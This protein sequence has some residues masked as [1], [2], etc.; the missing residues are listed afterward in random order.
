MRR[1]PADP[2]LAPSSASGRINIPPS[3]LFIASSRDISRCK[4]DIPL[5]WDPR[6]H[7]RDARDRARPSAR[8]AVFR[9][10]PFVDVGVSF[11]R[12]L[13]NGV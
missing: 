5:I 6:A 13:R 9:G 1:V 7:F 10:A 11:V 8:R 2:V 4:S 12:S 3:K